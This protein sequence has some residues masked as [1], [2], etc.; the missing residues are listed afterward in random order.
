MNQSNTRFARRK[1]NKGR[2]LRTGENQRK[3]LTY[4]YRY[5][6]AAGKRIYVYARDLQTL[7]KKEE[8]IRKAID[9]GIN[10]SEANVTVVELLERYIMLRQGLRHST[11]QGY[12][13]ILNLV[14]KEDFGYRKIGTIKSPAI[15]G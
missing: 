3:D 6:N 13:Q 12:R 2:V 7:R 4:Q 5:T 10:Y 9:D 15:A 14:K 1:D 11:K 8:K